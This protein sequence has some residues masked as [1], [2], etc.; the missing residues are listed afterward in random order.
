MESV[1]FWRNNHP[2]HVSQHAFDMIYCQSKCFNKFDYVILYLKV[3]VYTGD[4]ST[5]E[6]LSIIGVEWHFTRCIKSIEWVT[7]SC[8]M[9]LLAI[10]ETVKTTKMIRY[11]W[12]FKP[13]SLQWFSTRAAINGEISTVPLTRVNFHFRLCDHWIRWK[14]FFLKILEEDKYTYFQYVSLI[15]QLFIVISISVSYMTMGSALHHTS[16]I[17]ND[18]WSIIWKQFW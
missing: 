1:F 13:F 12:I 11:Q 4:C 15:V 8:S 10:I 6:H 2:L 17:I 9:Y 3:L 7:S 14:D 18:C 16:K 5:T